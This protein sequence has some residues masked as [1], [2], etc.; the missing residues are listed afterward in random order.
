MD[1]LVDEWDKQ[2]AGESCYLCAPHS[3]RYTIEVI[4]LS[5]STLY[6]ARDQRFLGYCGLVFDAYHAT[7]F[8]QLQD[9]DYSRFM[10]DLKLSV[11]VLRAVF[12]PDHINI[13]SLG[14]TCPHLHWGIIPRYRNDPR[15]GRSIWD[16]WQPNEF[17]LNP[18]LL[19]DAEYQLMVDR[20]R[21]EVLKVAG[22]TSVS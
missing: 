18:V 8:E 14:N 13:E 16:G 12:N 11:Q 2:A 1:N 4:S 7:Q 10:S 5:I 20:I 3:P 6:L 22:F 15:W 17:K 19:S 9:A 21:G